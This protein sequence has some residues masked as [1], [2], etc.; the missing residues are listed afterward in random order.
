MNDSDSTRVALRRC[1]KLLSWCFS[2][3]LLKRFWKRKLLSEFNAKKKHHS[4]LFEDFSF[5][6]KAEIRQTVRFAK[7]SLSK[8]RNGS[9]WFSLPLI[10]AF[11]VGF[12]KESRKA[13]SFF[14]ISFVA[15][16]FCLN[17]QGELS[18]QKNLEPIERWFS[19]QRSPSSIT[20]RQGS[21]GG[22]ECAQQTCESFLTMDAKVLE[23]GCILKENDFH[24]YCTCF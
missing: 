21:S 14:V 3:S 23:F 18:P 24:L 10:G 4:I 20:Y 11:F 5:C 19:D 17:R 6:D 22:T 9:L 8:V 15:Y 7:P 13:R 12:V 1:L 2:W 16:K